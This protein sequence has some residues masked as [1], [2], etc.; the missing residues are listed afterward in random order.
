[1]GDACNVFYYIYSQ[2]KI[3]KFASFRTRQPASGAFQII[4][5]WEAR[6]YHL[7]GAL[8]LFPRCSK[9]QAKAI[10][11]VVCIKQAGEIVH[12]I[13]ASLCALRVFCGQHPQRREANQAR[14]KSPWVTFRWLKKRLAKKN[15]GKDTRESAGPLNL[16]G[17]RSKT[18]KRS[19][20]MEYIRVESATK[21]RTWKSDCTRSAANPARRTIIISDDM[22]CFC[23]ILS[24][25]KSRFCFS[26]EFSC[27][28]RREFLDKHFC[29]VLFEKKHYLYFQQN[30][31]GQDLIFSS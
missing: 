12:Y 22:L 4:S 23:P 15:T 11:C 24:A 3:I 26:A 28:K 21:K 25:Q 10:K 27:T 5:S 1:M 20:I 6:F 8:F 16:R 9:S 30:L 18:A 2:N 13:F 17:A 7:A 29:Q 19:T 31:H 14:E